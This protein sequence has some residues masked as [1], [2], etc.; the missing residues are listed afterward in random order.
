MS[1][2]PYN[3][4]MKNVPVALMVAIVLVFALII[5]AFYIMSR[6]GLQMG[7]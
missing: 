3:D 5:F 6:G 1:N 2:Q 4:P 7:S